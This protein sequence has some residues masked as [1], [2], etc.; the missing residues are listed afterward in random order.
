MALSMWIGGSSKFAHADDTP[1]LV[2]MPAPADVAAPPP[3][4]LE[5]AA[6]VSMT[7]LKAGRGKERPEANDCVR[8]HFTAWRRDGSFL[9]SSR[10]RSEPDS[11]CLTT[12]FAGVADALQ[13]MVVGEERR[14]WV[15]AALTYKGDDSDASPPGTVDKGGGAS[16]RRADAAWPRVDVTFD[17]ELVEIQKAPPTPHELMAPPSLRKTPTGLAIQ[18]L[19]EGRGRDHPAPGRRVMLHFSGWTAG[20]RLI[21]SSVM[22]GQPASFEFEGVMPGWRE[23]L[24]SMVVGEQVRIWIPAA[25]AFGEK[26]RRGQPRGDLVYELDLLELQ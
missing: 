15:P 11:Q 13:T 23:A 19:H 14:L 7:I 10:P 22:G 6:G 8:V 16:P 1:A 9:A 24:Q 12:M 3:D 4:A 21:E 26:P 18:V 20:G 5:T 25:L 17:V 2:T